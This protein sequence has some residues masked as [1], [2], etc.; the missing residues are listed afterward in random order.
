MF[1]QLLLFFMTIMIVAC[2]GG[3]DAPFNSNNADMSVPNVSILEKS[4]LPAQPIILDIKNPVSGVSYIARLDIGGGNTI[5][6]PAVKRSET[7]VVITAPLGVYVGSGSN[8]T[9]K[10]GNLK[11]SLGRLSDNGGVSFS[12]VQLINIKPLPVIP[13]NIS[14]GTPTL[15]WLKATKLI[16][17]QADKSL[18]LASAHITSLNDSITAE[19]NRIKDVLGQL[20]ALQNA[21]QTALSSPNGFKWGSGVLDKSQIAMLDRMFTAQ[22]LAIRK[23]NAFSASDNTVLGAVMQSVDDEDVTL[24]NNF[25]DIGNMVKEMAQYARDVATKTREPVRALVTV[26]GVGALMFGSVPVATTALGLLVAQEFLISSSFGTYV[27]AYLD[28]QADELLKGKA[29]VESLRATGN[30]FVNKYLDLV[31]DVGGLEEKLAGEI[32][33]GMLERV[34]QL[35]DE[36]KKVNSSI[37]TA[38]DS[39]QIP[40]AAIEDVAML[41]VTSTS[42]NVATINQLSTFTAYGEN[43]TNGMTMSLDGC[44]RNSVGSI[45]TN[46]QQQFTCT[47]L[48]VGTKFGDWIDTNTNQVIASFSV[49]VISAQIAKPVITSITPAIAILGTSTV[50]TA[51]GSNLT[52]TMPVILEGCKEDL[53][54]S[55]GSETEQQFTCTPS[56]AGVKKGVWKD[57]E[58]GA[59]I[60]DFTVDVSTDINLGVVCHNESDASGGTIESCVDQQGKLQG[61]WQWWSVNKCLISSYTYVNGVKSGP[62]KSEN[63]D[64]NGCWLKEE[65]GFKNDKKSGEWRH[66][67]DS[68]NSKIGIYLVEIDQYSD[69]KLDGVSKFYG[70]DSKSSKSYLSVSVSYQMDEK[71]GEQYSYF[72]DGRPQ[73]LITYVNGHAE[74][75][76][77][78]WI[79]TTYCNGKV[80]PLLYYLYEEGVYVNGKETSVK[81]HLCY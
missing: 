5:D 7:Q 4:V 23:K 79:Q 51:H 57:V 42:P 8:L 29:N 35:Y 56:E 74:G 55:S 68:Y 63:Q 58:T 12:D 65:G 40:Q 9:L 11:L 73:E 1:K 61:L 48:S 62:Y 37:S 53:I 52:N 27:G 81:R 46:A 59:G 2:G 38:I 49:D 15:V 30:F 78:R 34:N 17:L 72:V 18:R 67:A 16:Y 6:V 69:G 47:P 22:M 64:E 3:G 36:A 25:Y 33:K 31:G 39:N 54:V 14:L 28:V 43:L 50:F 75:V 44:K 60:Y 10:D 32:G 70:V 20:D 13:A 66:Y 76:F 21:V 26:M 45:G 77:K 80:V 24:N 19:R 71:S 41:I